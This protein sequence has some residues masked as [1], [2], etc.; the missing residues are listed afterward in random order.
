MIE[1]L[2]KQKEII[3]KA[4]ELYK[5][6]YQIHCSLEAHIKEV[7]ITFYTDTKYYNK[8][9]EWQYNFNIFCFP[10]N[11]NKNISSIKF[12]Y[13]DDDRVYNAIM[14]T[15]KEIEKK[16]IKVYDWNEIKK[17]YRLKS[18]YSGV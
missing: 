10:Y 13:S 16:S 5:Q 15:F 6:G 3:D 17:D 7:Y 4:F 1:Y 8:H 2:E 14:D 9:T 11:L 18:L 12:E